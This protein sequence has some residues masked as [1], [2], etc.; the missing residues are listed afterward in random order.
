MRILLKLRISCR[1]R[2]SDPRSS[3]NILARSRWR[4]TT[5]RP[6]A[7]VTVTP[8]I[9]HSRNQRASWVATFSCGRT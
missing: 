3:S 2:R 1:L 5:P 9:P 7:V 4:Y 8:S 6:S